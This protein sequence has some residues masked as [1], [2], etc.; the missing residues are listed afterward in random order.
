MLLKKK[1][2]QT[3]WAIKSLGLSPNE[4]QL[5]YYVTLTSVDKF[6]FPEYPTGLFEQFTEKSMKE[7]DIIPIT[8]FELEKDFKKSNY[9]WEGTSDLFPISCSM[10]QNEAKLKEIF[11]EAYKRY[12]DD[13]ITIDEFHKLMEEN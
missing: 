5:V 3:K 6:S 9:N 7:Q 2:S 10:V 1:A 12:Q 11:E 13:E 8:I 4:E